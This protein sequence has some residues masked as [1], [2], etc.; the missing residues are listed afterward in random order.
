MENDDYFAIIA[1]SSHTLLLTEDAVNGLVEAFWCN[2]LTKSAKRRREIFL[3]NSG[4]PEISPGGVQN[5]TIEN[6]QTLPESRSG[7][8]FLEKTFLAPL[9]ERRQNRFRS[10]HVRFTRSRQHII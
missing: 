4:I 10:S 2:F 3:L 5:E 7:R 8:T 9:D 1:S 6:P